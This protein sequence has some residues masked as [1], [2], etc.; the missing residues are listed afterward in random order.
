VKTT[1]LQRLVVAGHVDHGKSTLIGSLLHHVTEAQRGPVGPK[2]ADFAHLADSLIEERR[3]EQT[4]D[5]TQLHIELG[6]RRLVLIDVPG[7]EELTRHMLTGATLADAALLVLAADRGIEVQTRRHLVLLELLGLRSI[8]VAITRLDLCEEPDKAFST[9]RAEILAAFPSSALWNFVPVDAPA[10]INL[11]P[12]SPRHPWYQGPSLLEVLTR[13]DRAECARGSELAVFP[14]QGLHCHEGTTYLLGR[15]LGGTLEVGRSYHFLS[16]AGTDQHVT[17]AALLHHGKPVKRGNTGQNL[18]VGLDRDS[19][20]RRGCLLAGRLAPVRVVASVTATL[21]WLESPRALPELEL[22]LQTQRLQVTHC[23]LLSG[24]HSAT[25]E[26]LPLADNAPPP[27]LSLTD[28]YLT[29]AAPLIAAHHSELPTMG[30]FVLA[31]QGHPI[32]AGIVRH[33]PA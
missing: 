10:G 20:P 6:D 27:P 24:L 5:T 17:I 26:P 4:F 32:A 28:A 11:L 23:N 22:L 1:S 21:L 29:F 33:L 15:L 13:T 25:L 14:I 18:A 3:G 7:H 2:P 31:E 12:T 8:T 30:R 9:R 19:S 16:Q